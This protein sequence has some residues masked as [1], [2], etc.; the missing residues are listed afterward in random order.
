MMAPQLQS[1]SIGLGPD[2]CGGQWSTENSLCSSNQFE[3]P[4]HHRPQSGL[5]KQG[6]TQ[7]LLYCMNDL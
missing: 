3:T 1:L 7:I 6:K 5:L 4:T 2:D